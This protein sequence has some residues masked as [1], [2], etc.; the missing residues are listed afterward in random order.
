MYVSQFLE[1]W[2]LPYVTA[3]TSS[4]L[5]QSTKVSAVL[6]DI[7]QHAIYM[8]GVEGKY[9]Y[10]LPPLKAVKLTYTTMNLHIWT[11]NLL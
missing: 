3:I 6:F 2:C 5:I 7:F 8:I 4:S 10:S 9:K 1:V 11:T